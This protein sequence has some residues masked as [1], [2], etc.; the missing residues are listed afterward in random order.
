MVHKGH[1]HVNTGQLNRLSRGLPIH[2]LPAHDGPHL[3]KKHHSIAVHLTDEGMNQLEKL[4]RS[5]ARTGHMKKM[6]LHHLPHPKSRHAHMSGEGFFD[7]LS[8]A[9]NGVKNAVTNTIAPIV[10]K[11]ADVAGNVASFVPDPRFQAAA[12]ALKTVGGIANAISAKPTPSTEQQEVVNQQTIA[13]IQVPNLPPPASAIPEPVPLQV[14]AHQRP[15]YNPTVAHVKPRKLPSQKIHSKPV[16][17]LLEKKVKKKTKGHMKGRGLP[18]ILEEPTL[19][20]ENAANLPD[21][22]TAHP[23][24]LQPTKVG[25][26]GRRVTRRHVPHF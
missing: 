11:V 15:S 8:D 21:I 25:A 26:E 23:N 5:H 9:Y 24:L 19:I 2:A 13:P 10:G 7:F 17:K 14:L 16:K 4:H 20:N 18:H 1:F 12:G 6:Y 3:S 22:L